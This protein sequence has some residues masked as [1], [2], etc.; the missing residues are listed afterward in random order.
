MK[1]KHAK[2]FVF[3]KWLCW[4][5]HRS[6]SI[7]HSPMNISRAQP[8]GS[9]NVGNGDAASSKRIRIRVW[10]ITEM[11][12]Q[13]QCQR[14]YTYIALS[15]KLKYTFCALLATATK[16]SKCRT[17]KV[18]HPKRFW[19]DFWD[20]PS[21]YYKF[22]YN[23]IFN[24]ITRQWKVRK[25]QFFLHIFTHSSFDKKSL[26]AWSTQELDFWINKSQTQ[27]LP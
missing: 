25:A 23:K 11:L 21:F 14:F 10:Q 27:Q 17:V 6:E 3:Q 24:W 20:L 15:L 7:L 2:I 22:P 1:Q 5:T 8:S 4:T 9:V 26:L 18:F 13:F 12:L 16:L 19:L